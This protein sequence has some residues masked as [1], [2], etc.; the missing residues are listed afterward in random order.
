M[1]SCFSLPPF[2]LLLCLMSY[3]SN[4]SA[5]YGNNTSHVSSLLLMQTELSLVKALLH[6]PFPELLNRL[7]ISQSFS[8]AV[9]QQHSQILSLVTVPLA[10]SIFGSSF[11][12][13]VLSLQQWDTSTSR[14]CGGGGAW[15]HPAWNN[16]HCFCRSW[17]WP[18]DGP[19]PHHQE[20]QHVRYTA[21]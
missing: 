16:P 17:H 3:V 4:Y 10:H 15:G 2:L 6:F 1:Y 13:C 7:S 14:L 19:R 5:S 20:H 18:E 21:F 11:P 12:S 8:Q 9:R